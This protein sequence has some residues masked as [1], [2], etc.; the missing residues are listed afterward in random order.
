MADIED[1][2]ALGIILLGHFNSIVH[3][4]LN[5]CVKEQ[6]SDVD[7]EINEYLFIEHM[8]IFSQH[9]RDTWKQIFN[10]PLPEL[11]SP[12]YQDIWEESKKK[13]MPRVNQNIKNIKEKYKQD[14]KDSDEYSYFR[15]KKET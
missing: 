2:R 14:K 1:E 11:T 13:A 15:Q 7:N 3:H 8:V 5:N 6:N 9:I 12:Q 4:L 10:E